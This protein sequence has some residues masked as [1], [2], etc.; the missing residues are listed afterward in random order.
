MADLQKRI[1]RT[2]SRLTEIL[3]EFGCLEGLGVDE[4]DFR[5]ALGQFGPVW[6]SLNTCEQVTIIRILIQQVAYNTKT[7]KVMVIFRS[8]GIREM[9]RGE[10]KE[11][12]NRS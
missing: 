7:N 4:G 6:E 3:H 5:A 1:V 9:C 8:A 11:G 12:A 2:E 10:R